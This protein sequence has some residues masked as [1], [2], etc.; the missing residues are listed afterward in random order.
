MFHKN[1]IALSLYSL[2]LIFA[3]TLVAAE[4]TIV[5][6][7]A[8]GWETVEKRSQIDEI[9]GVRPRTVLTLS[10]A[11][12]GSQ[13]IGGTNSAGGTAAAAGTDDD[14]LA[15]YAM[16]RNYPVQ[17][18]ALDLALS[19]D[20]GRPENFADS[21]GRYRVNAAG[22]V[23]SVDERHAR[24]GR[25]AALFIGTDQN[26]SPPLTI[27]PTSTALFAPG[28]NVRD[29]SIDFWLFPGNMG[30]GEQI[31][32]WNASGNQRIFCESLRNRIRW[33]FQ[34]FFASPDRLRSPSPAERSPAAQERISISLESRA[35]I[36][37][38]KWSHHLIRYN[39]DTGLLEYLVN[40][41]IENM[42]YTTPNGRE[43]GDVYTPLV[44]RDGYFTLGTRFSG[45]M[46][47][48]RI[49]NK[50]INAP[51]HTALEQPDPTALD[52]PELAKFPRSGGRIETR[53]IDLGQPGSAVLMIEASGGRLGPAP[54][55]RRLTV[56]NTYAG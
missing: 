16:Y 38:R 41:R 25:G 42:T 54:A 3:T 19:F 55:G 35:V 43:G 27:K 31:I 2:S 6:G 17:E 32:T 1:G 10:S 45:M 37:S 15:L 36:L 33:T 23:Q 40:G 14:I 30:N 9:P 20:E 8:A 22:A 12:T 47:E 46:D 34:D 29:F 44:N 18:S 26:G 5:L 7:A 56:K 13:S 24:Y 28:R 49:Y 11:W 50:V 4:K 21:R 48:F 53:S 52:L 39:A 51:G